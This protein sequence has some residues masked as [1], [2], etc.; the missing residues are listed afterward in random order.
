M[1]YWGWRPLILGL[2]MSTWVAGCNIVTEHAAPST[3]PTT[4]PSVTLTVGR[5]A[6]PRAAPTRAIVTT[7]VASVGVPLT[8]DHPVCYETREYSRLCLGLITNPLPYAV[9]GVVVEVQLAA[10]TQQIAI[11]QTII[12]PGGF[13]PY[14]V[15]F[16]TRLSGSGT[17]RVI[18]A[19]RSYDETILELAVES[20]TAQQLGDGRVIITA[21]VN[22]TNLLPVDALLAVVTLLND[23]GQV[24]G[25]RAVDLGA[26]GIHVEPGASFPLR[27]IVAPQT[28]A[29]D[30][31]YHVHVEGHKVAP[32]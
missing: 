24:I 1:G 11:A 22:N 9:S 8:Y 15:V 6:S 16:D 21:T 7:A 28:S 31:S 2:F 30:A 3:L 19:E 12:P 10:L 27:V 26:S 13:A 14:Q 23:A 17:A 5:L 20:V 25:Y 29:E 18:N 32:R 4:Y